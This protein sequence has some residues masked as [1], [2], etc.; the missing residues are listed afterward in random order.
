MLEFSQIL[1]NTFS[2]FFLIFNDYLK[3]WFSFSLLAGIFISLF[4]LFFR[5]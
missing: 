4:D 5:K 2:N 3:F 1:E